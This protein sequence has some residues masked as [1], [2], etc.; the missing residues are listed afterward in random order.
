MSISWNLEGRPVDQENGI[1]MI[2]IGGRTNLLTI[3]S[4]Q[5]EHAGEYTCRAENSAGI[6]SHSA[7]LYING[8]FF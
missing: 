4:V 3:A 8:T 2:T 5:A 6:A 1:S 7:T